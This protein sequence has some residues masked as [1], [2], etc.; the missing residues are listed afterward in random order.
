MLENVG[1][2][3]R[4]RPNAGRTADA[5][6]L[7]HDGW[8]AT[9]Q[10][11]GERRLAGPRESFHDTHRRPFAEPLNEAVQRFGAVRPEEFPGRDHGRIS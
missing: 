9:H 7:L 1:R 10:L 5:M 11:T 3:R 2:L 6:A 4:G 8:Y